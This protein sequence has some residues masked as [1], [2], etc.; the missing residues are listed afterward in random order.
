MAIFDRT[1][2][3]T[4]ASAISKLN[5]FA[6]RHEFLYDFLSKLNGPCPLPAEILYL[7]A[8][9]GSGK[10]LLLRYMH[11]RSCYLLD[12]AE[13]D[14][15]RAG[16]LATLVERVREARKPIAVA[17]ALLD[18]GAQ[19]IGE[20]R[21]LEALP[22][23]FMLKRQLARFKVAT[24][25]FD[26]AALNYLQKSGLDY[27]KTLPELFPA[28][29]LDFA[30]NLMDALASLPFAATGR[31]LLTLID[32]R[33]N[34]A[35]AR[36]RMQRPVE[37]EYVDMIMESAADPDLADLLPFF[38][39]QDLNNA[40][41]NKGATSRIA[42]FFDTHEAFWGEDLY[43]TRSSISLASISRDKWL[44]SLLGGIDLERGIVVVVAGRKPPRWALAEE[45]AI[46]EEYVDAK[47]V[48]GLSPADAAWY[49]DSAGIKDPRLQSQVIA[50]STGEPNEVH[51]FM[52]GLYADVLASPAGVEGGADLSSNIK[53]SLED[54]GRLLVARLMSSVAEGMQRNVIAVAAT[55]SFGFTEFA[56]LADCLRLNGSYDDFSRLVNFSFILE[57]RP[58]S[59]SAESGEDTAVYA[60][61]QLLRRELARSFP[62]QTHDAD[63]VLYEYYA[64]KQGSAAQAEAALHLMRVD[65]SRGVKF[66]CAA[67]EELLDAGRYRDCI[68]FVGVV[69]D[70][71]DPKSQ[72]DIKVYYRVAQVY[73]GIGAMEDAKSLLAQLPVDS[74]EFI[75]LKADIE[76]CDCEYPEAESTARK[77][78]SH[79]PVDERERLRLRLAEILLYTG[80]FADARDVLTGPEFRSPY[81]PS[82][83]ML[84]G[85]VEY[86]AGNPERAGELF[87]ACEEQLAA[88]PA[89]EVNL[90]ITGW[91]QSGLGLIRLWQRDW[92]SAYAHFEASL[93]VREKAGH[94]RGIANCHWLMGQA[95]CGAGLHTEGR[96]L[97]ARARQM[98]MDQGDEITLAKVR[99]SEA[100]SFFD[101]GETRKAHALLDDVVAN[102]DADGA[103][104]DQAHERLEL[105]RM[106][107]AHGDFRGMVANLDAAR[108]AMQGREFGLLEQT[109]PDAVSAVARRMTSSLVAFAVG[110]AVGAPVEGLPSEAIS[111]TLDEPIGQRD[112]WPVGSTSDDTDQLLAVGQAIASSSEEQDPARR[113]LEL[114]GELN[115]T[116]RGRGPTT[117][118]AVQRFLKT[119]ELVA[120]G[121]STNG[122]VVRAVAVGWAAPV[123]AQDH[124]RALVERLTRTTHAAPSA[125][126]SAQVVAAMSAWS[127]EGVDPATLVEVAGEELVFTIR[128]YDPDE[129][130][131][132]TMRDALAG[133]WTAPT[134]TGISLDAIETTAAAISIVRDASSLAESMLSAIR[135]GGDTD[136][137]AALVGGLLGALYPAEV[138]ALPW[139]P[140]VRIPDHATAIVDAMV[141]YRWAR[142]A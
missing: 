43:P 133:Q 141:R 107:R 25:R 93:A 37:D 48:A 96:A 68:P 70:V 101:G 117:M 110:D 26:F 30:V 18:F 99:H 6:D 15:V 119:G 67:V 3:R 9:G 35:F 95:K 51:P 135:L 120:T 98:A 138:D 76:F 81:C 17:S 118:T 2:A 63:V 132:A 1:G 129:H 65:H 128:A 66:W 106:C 104:Y 16:P 73:I 14:V 52:L 7:H 36:W 53:S 69:M 91:N 46:A 103:P 116:M 60:V 142:Y 79:V 5:H 125:L 59:A 140:Q 78:I 12:A 137:M 123:A 47:S 131:V 97:L 115:T 105:A 11:A 124:R 32:K 114:L 54:R 38:F 58:G 74:A 84:L 112:D 61:H 21:P 113:L 87:R 44:R 62:K 100:V 64:V 57:K 85:E 31:A 122:A 28:S 13:W 10:S 45:A 134:T 88:T 50:Y 83:Y 77:G 4:P 111:M 72:I 139:L 23:L 33:T 29:E 82:W 136:T 102:N 90:T 108:R 40:L 20:K 8:M 121:G 42:L 22:A 80:H 34:N 86:F 89:Q 55:R 92:D 109:Y 130:D 126:V 19:P 75:L 39:A 41:T 94:A 49:L 24:P 127:L 27:K 71:S 56:Y